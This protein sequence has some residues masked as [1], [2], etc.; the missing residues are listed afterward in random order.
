MPLRKNRGWRKDRLLTD[1]S[2]FDYDEEIS[3]ETLLERDLISHAFAILPDGR[4][5][6]IAG[7]QSIEDLAISAH[8]PGGEL[9]VGWEI[10]PDTNIIDRLILERGWTPDAPS[11]LI[12]IADKTLDSLSPLDTEAA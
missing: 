6:D 7:A 5:I 1:L 12:A 2:S 9:G 10:R 8:W 11:D 3:I 4:A